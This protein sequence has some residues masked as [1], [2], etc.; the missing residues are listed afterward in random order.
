MVPAHGDRAPLGAGAGAPD[1]LRAAAGVAASTPLAFTLETPGAPRTRRD[2]DVGVKVQ[3]VPGPS[4]KPQTFETVEQIE[5]RA[6]WNAMRPRLTTPQ[7]LV[8]DSTGA[9]L[10]GTGTDLKIGDAL[11][12]MDA[13]RARTSSDEHWDFRRVTSVRPDH[14]NQRTRVEWERGLGSQSPLMTPAT[15]ISVFALRTRASLFGYNAIDPKLLPA[16]AFTSF[17]TAGSLD[18]TDASDPKWKFPITGQSIAL[19]A[20]YPTIRAGS[21]VVLAKPD[22]EEL[23][24]VDFAAEAAQSDYGLSS[25]TTQLSLA[26]GQNL[27]QFA[28]SSLPATMVFGETELLLQEEGPIDSPTTPRSNAVTLTTD[29][30]EIPAGRRLLVAGKDAAGNDAVETIVLDH[31]EAVTGTRAGTTFQVSR[32]V[33]ATA[34]ANEY[35]LET[36]T[37]YGNVALA[38]HGETVNEVLGGGNAGKSYQRFTLRQPPLTFVR[39]DDAVNGA[40]STLEL[41]VNDLLWQEVPW[42]YRRGSA[43]RVFATRRDEDGNTVLQFGDGVHGARL[44]TGQENIRASYRKGVGTSGNVKAGQ[45]TTLLTRPLGLKGATNP[46]PATGGDDPEPRDSARQNAPLN[47][48]TLD[49]VV[50]LRDYEDFARAYSGVAKAL[51]T[52]SWDGERR[53]VLITV[54]GPDGAAVADDVLELLLGAI[55]KAGDPFVALRVDSYRPAAFTDELQGQ[56]RPGVRKAESLCRARGCAARGLRLQGPCLRPARGAIRCDR[57]IAERRRCHRRR[58]RHAGPNGWRRRRWADQSAA[59]RTPSGKLALGGASRGA[60]DACR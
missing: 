9:W 54:A 51:A 47:V 42:F 27:Q 45:L 59:R 6:E 36:V 28:A 32:L 12:L 20:P 19:D 17:S 11:L 4:E 3:S 39:D 53:G 14:D 41:R 8:S 40:V 35:K 16:N 15:P 23:Y 50:S 46:Q 30:G 33:F 13:G 29:V 5:A 34:L 31:V 24:Y 60:P 48:L 26:T 43:E 7:T 56:G 55:R 1:R 25:R 49:R 57:D 44:P 38:S 58:R 18:T 37:I 22:Y 10:D 2:L 21:W 52:W